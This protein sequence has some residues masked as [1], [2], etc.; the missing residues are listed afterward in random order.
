[1]QKIL[2][3]ILILF[4]CQLFASDDWWTERS[5]TIHR[6]NEEHVNQVKVYGQSAR[7]MRE[8]APISAGTSQT[9]RD[10]VRRSIAVDVPTATKVGTP[11]LQRIKH[12]I[13]APGSKV[14]GVYAVMQLLEGIGWVMEDGT[15]VKKIPEN[16]DEPDPDYQY[17]F[18]NDLYDNSTQACQAFVAS[19]SFTDSYGSGYVF[20]RVDNPR[21]SYPVCVSYKKTENRYVSDQPVQRVPRQ[22]PAEEPKEKTVPLTPALLGAAMLGQGYKDPDPNF[23]NDTVNTDQD[24]GVKEIYEHDPSGIG[25]ERADDMDDKLKNA[26]PTGDGKSSYIGDPKYDEK[27]LTDGDTSADRSWDNDAG[28]AT[29]ESKPTV[30]PETGEATGGQS[31]SLKFPVFCEWASIV[32]EWIDWTKEEPELEDEPLEIEEKELIEYERLNP[33]QFGQTC[34][35]T[36]TTHALQLGVLGTL[37]FETDLTFICTT[38]VDARP[39]IIGIGHLAALIFLLIGLRNGNA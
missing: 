38:A 25:N 1:M 5:I 3:I 31:I 9:A 34:P 7:M 16:S 28:E 30:D 12:V 29:G 8:N 4:S 14:L 35:F 10:I 24:T 37:E 15:Y 27:P 19:S 18:K 36:P 23:N 39:Y 6:A 13:K 20:S 17:K 2:M 26:K 33:I 22:T 21:A 32:C 11:M